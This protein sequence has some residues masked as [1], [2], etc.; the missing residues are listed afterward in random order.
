MDKKFLLLYVLPLV[1]YAGFIIVLS[2]IP[3]VP[4]IRGIVS[5]EPV[6]PGSWTGD[7]IEHIFE[8][9]ILAFLFYRMMMQTKYQT[10]AVFATIIFCVLFGMTD[11]LHQMF[12]LTRTPSFKDLFFDFV[13]G[14]TINLSSRIKNYNRIR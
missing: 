5:K 6:A 13:G 14:L 2:S 10:H 4:T 7:D 3:D 12:V 8:Y 1:L 9:G 11:E